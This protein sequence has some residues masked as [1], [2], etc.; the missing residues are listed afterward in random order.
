MNS[1]EQA[2]LISITET[3]LIRVTRIKSPGG[4]T[5]VSE[6]LWQQISDNT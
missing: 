3:S 4:K 5:L 6:I 1:K 2:V